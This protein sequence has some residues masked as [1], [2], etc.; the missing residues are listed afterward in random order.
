[1]RFGVH[2]RSASQ[3]NLSTFELRTHSGYRI[4]RVFIT[5]V[6]LKMR[7]GRAHGM[8]A[9]VSN[10]DGGHTPMENF[11][12]AIR[13]MRNRLHSTV[14]GNAECACT[15]HVHT[16]ASLYV[17]GSWPTPT[18]NEMKR[19]STTCCLTQAQSISLSV[20]SLPH[21]LP[22]YPNACRTR[23]CGHEHDA[24]MNTRTHAYTYSHAHTYCEALAC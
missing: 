10:A 6:L 2:I 19:R 8:R 21:R 20:P 4:G 7:H 9:D 11:G 1:M 18:S 17:D 22:M 14:D 23:M 3:S 24:W 13:W 12:H 16:Y 15:K 5:C